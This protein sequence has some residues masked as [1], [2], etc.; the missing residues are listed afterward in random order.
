MLMDMNACALKMPPNRTW[1]DSHISPRGAFAGSKAFSKAIM[2]LKWVACS[3]MLSSI[4]AENMIEYPFITSLRS[5]G[6]F[7]YSQITY[8][9]KMKT[10]IFCRKLG[11]LPD[12]E[13]KNEDRNSERAYSPNGN[14]KGNLFFLFLFLFNRKDSAMKKKQ[15]TLSNIIVG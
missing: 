8:R 1:S 4:A 5:W 12:V 6:V 9:N 7:I 14:V 3:K 10:T 13:A 15:A 2:G 11:A